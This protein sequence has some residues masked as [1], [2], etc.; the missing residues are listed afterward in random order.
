MDEWTAARADGDPA[1]YP[2]DECMSTGNTVYRAFAYTCTYVI[3]T[4]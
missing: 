2:M 4:I 1:R 3:P